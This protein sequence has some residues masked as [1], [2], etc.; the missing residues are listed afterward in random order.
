VG[1][2]RKSF[3]GTLVDG[4]P[5]AAH[6]RLEGTIA[7]STWAVMEGASMVRVHDVRPAVE[8]VRIIGDR[9]VG[10]IA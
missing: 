6:D 10:E 7:T 8:A 1:T 2:S 4:A 5:A 9:V 3:L